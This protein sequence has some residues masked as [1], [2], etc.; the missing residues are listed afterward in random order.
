MS[1]PPP[2]GGLGSNSNYILTSLCNNITGLTVTINVTQNIVHKDS[3]GIWYHGFGFQLNC[4]SAPH[5]SNAFQQFI[6]ILLGTPIGDPQIN[7]ALN[8]YTVGSDSIY[9]EYFGVLAMPN[10]VLPAGYQ[11]QMQLKNDTKDNIVG[12]TWTVTDLGFLPA[13][14][15]PIT[16]YWSPSPLQN[17]P[18]LTRQHVNY[19]GIDGHIHERL[20]DPSYNWVDN[21]LTQLSGNGIAPADGSALDAYFGPDN[22]QH[23]NFIG[24]DGH[25][26]ELYLALGG[27]W[28]NNDLTQLS[29][30]ILPLPNT[31]LDGYVDQDGGQ[32]VNF[33]GNDNHVH[34]LFIPSHG[35]W[36][37]NDLIHKSGD[38]I[39]PRPNSPLDGYIDADNGQHVNFIDTDGHVRELYITPHGQWVNNDLIQKS[40]NGIAPS[41][42]STL[43]GYLGPDNGQHV[44]FIGTDGHVR[45]LYITPHGQWVNNDLTHL[46]GDS[47]PPAPGSPLSSYWGD[48]NSQ[49]VNFIGTD[50]HVREH[51]IH[52]DAQWV[53]NDLTQLSG[54]GT[55]PVPGSAL[56]SYAQPDGEQHVNFISP[57]DAHLHEL[58]ARPHHQWVNND[59]N[60]LQLVNRT[61]Q[62]LPLKTDQFAPI[63]AFQVNLVGPI[64]SDSAVLSS[65][66]GTITYSAVT[67]LTVQNSFPSCTASQ[68]G[69][70]ETANS[71]YGS[72]DAGPSNL[73]TQTFSTSAQPMIHFH[74]PTKGLNLPL[75]PN[76]PLKPIRR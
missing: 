57:G 39:G 71:F 26:R 46:S 53:N 70:A 43:C 52:P 61:I 7:L 55:V 44:N 65:G 11:L 36:I 72:L 10:L 41:R 13:P 4:N 49:H 74:G 24:T 47:T 38:G 16:G 1:V 9:L 35:H 3:S 45:E 37:D 28:I 51:Y 40:G 66:A 34:E 76:K 48:N 64:N 54:N 62:P 6:F 12:I 8:D 56:H 17:P 20:H 58:Y 73:I 22:G 42:N 29:K 15:T 75:E 23:I 27:Q 67:P 18:V 33:I 50:G 21:D 2:G 68:F 59:L 14:N 25:V 19:I 32:H 60:N 30:G 5:F 69:T 31:P 63:N